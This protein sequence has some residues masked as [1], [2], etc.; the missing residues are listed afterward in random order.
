MHPQ[1]WVGSLRALGEE[2][3]ENGS[4]PAK[5]FADWLVRQQVAAALEGCVATHTERAV[6]HALDGFADQALHLAHALDAADAIADH[7][8]IKQSLNTLVQNDAGL[9]T[10]LLV[11]LL[12]A[13]LARSTG[14]RTVI[15]D[16]SLH[17]TCV[18]RLREITDHA[19]R[20]P[21]DWTIAFAL[22]CRCEDCQSLERF[23]QSEQH[24]LD[25]PLN[26]QRRGHIH[27]AIDSSK[28]P[29]S[30]ATLR[31]GRPYVL[32]LR[33]LPSLFSDDAAYTEKAKAI[34]RELPP[35]RAPTV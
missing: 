31:R 21:G 32:Q 13:S 35:L 19:P 17:R 25:W 2:F 34:L 14:L 1:P 30:H 28:L 27:R 26:E 8:L 18:R 29:I 11:Q 10:A 9:Q 20:A 33:K 4:G 24:T 23:V 6:W 12:Q 5:E 22:S 3:H 16:S 15:V 7:A